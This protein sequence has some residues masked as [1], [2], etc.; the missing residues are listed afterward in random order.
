MAFADK[1]S[2]NNCLHC[3]TLDIFTRQMEK[4]SM[5]FT[6]CNQNILVIGVRTSANLYLYYVVCYIQFVSHERVYIVTIRTYEAH[7]DIVVL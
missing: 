1:R 6:S 5:L 3:L 7:I 2:P 4:Y